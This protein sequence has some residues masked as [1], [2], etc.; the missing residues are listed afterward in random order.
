MLTEREILKKKIDH[1]FQKEAEVKHIKI[2]IS[3]AKVRE[4][5]LVRIVCKNDPYSTRK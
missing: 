4:R 3:M 2:S 5:S 1:T